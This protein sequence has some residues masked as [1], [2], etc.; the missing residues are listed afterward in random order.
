MTWLAV[1]GVF[2]GMM[3]VGALTPNDSAGPWC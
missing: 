3:I 1:I 2:L